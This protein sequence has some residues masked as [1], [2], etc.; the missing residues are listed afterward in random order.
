ME[1]K[2]LLEAKDVGLVR[3]RL[4]M[5]HGMD[6]TLVGLLVDIDRDIAEPL[7]F[8]LAGYFG[9]ELNRKI[10]MGDLTVAMI[11]NLL[12]LAKKPR[13][14]GTVTREAKEAVAAVE[15]VEANGAVAAVAAVEAQDAVEEVCSSGSDEERQE[16]YLCYEPRY[17]EAAPRRRRR[18]VNKWF[19][20]GRLRCF[21]EIFQISNDAGKFGGQP[22]QGE[23][24]QAVEVG[25]VHP[26]LHAL[27]DQ[28]CGYLSGSLRISNLTSMVVSKHGADTARL[29]VHKMT[30]ADVKD[31]V[32]RM[33]LEHEEGGVEYSFDLDNLASL[34]VITL[35]L[36][37][38]FAK[39]L[40]YSEDMRIRYNHIKRLTGSDKLAWD[41]SGDEISRKEASK[42]KVGI[43]REVSVWNWT[44]FY[45][46]WELTTPDTHKGSKKKFGNHQ[47]CGDY[48]TAMAKLAALP[49]VTDHNFRE[50]ADSSIGRIMGHMNVI[51]DGP[52]SPESSKSHPYSLR[53]ALI[54]EKEEL[55]KVLV[56]EG[57]LIRSINEVCVG[58][59]GTGDA[60]AAAISAKTTPLKGAKGGGGGGKEAENTNRQ[61]QQLQRSMDKVQESNKRMKLE[62]NSSRGGGGGGF[63]GGGGGGGGRKSTPHSGGGGIGRPRSRSPLRTRGPRLQC[64]SSG[65]TSGSLCHRCK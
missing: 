55:K 27:F 31:N 2:A 16:S 26:A 5:H 33:S 50:H 36:D 45:L 47:S 48:D 10:A 54:A 40:T 8:G 44:M 20:F 3:R 35:I 37:Q 56:H 49:G 32:R 65:C 39:S 53:E 15:A 6:A 52:Y 19:L 28:I 46:S 11:G 29:S 13:R 7:S 1:R 42:S 63:G 59:G 25:R 57:R 61:L 43:L 18:P 9:N 64:R 38:G 24:M 21:A 12:V 58:K 17:A 30:F 4:T 22:L 60:D 23:D 41:N 34:D 51:P 14:E 62:L